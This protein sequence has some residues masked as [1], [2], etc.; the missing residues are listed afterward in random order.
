[1]WERASNR[2]IG[3]L[4]SPMIASGI[5]GITTGLAAAVCQSLSYLATRYYVQP[6][7][8]GASK[9]LLVLSNIEM[10]IPS[11]ILLAYYW[12]KFPIDWSRAIIPL[13]GVIIFYILGQLGLMIA[14]KY[15]EPS[16]V[17]PLLG[18][19]LVV[20][21]LLTAFLT[22]Q[23][24]NLWQWVAVII[25][26]FGALSL[27]RSGGRMP[28]KAT[29][30][31]VIACVSYSLSDWNITGV[32][33]AMPD[34][35][36]LMSRCFFSLALNY[37]ITG[38][39]AL[40]LLP[41]IHITGR[42]DW[43][44]SAPF[45][46]SWFIAMVFLFLCFGLVGPLYGNILQSTRGIISIFMGWALVRLGSGHMEPNQGKGDFLRKLAAGTLMFAA[47]VLYKLVS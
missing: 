35:V 38:I 28:M 36:P 46:A 25:C 44:D 19:K 20:L 33:H 18:F 11:A 10:G 43:R 2:A 42:R 22:T 3:V 8:S 45:A 37:T 5:L 39:L 34:D 6:R 26:L 7:P 23:G 16:R 21:A 41:F 12:G 4:S 31:L 15:A 32:I 30:A 27:Y 40:P 9:T 17:S 13:A 14:L 47:V 29:L 1:M 24:V